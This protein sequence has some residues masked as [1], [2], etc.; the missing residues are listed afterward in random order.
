[1]D[2]LS[3]FFSVLGVLGLSD[4]PTFVPGLLG[5]LEPLASA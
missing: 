3:F 5:G 2:C 4:A 1:M